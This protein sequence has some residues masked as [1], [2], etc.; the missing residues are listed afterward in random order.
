[1]LAPQ[2]DGEEIPMFIVTIDSFGEQRIVRGEALVRHEMLRPL[3]DDGFHVVTDRVKEGFNG[4]AKFGVYLPGVLE[5]VAAGDVDMLH[6]QAD[7]GSI[8]H[9]SQ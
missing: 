3:T 7:H 9:A 4:L 5:H 1:M 8:A 6:F 2:P